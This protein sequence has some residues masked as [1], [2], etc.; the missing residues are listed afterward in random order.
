GTRNRV[1]NRFR[2]WG[3]LTSAKKKPGF[4]ESCWWVARV[5][6]RNPVSGPKKETGFLGGQETGFRR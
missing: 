6:A 4:Y 3:H 1:S 2:C 5:N